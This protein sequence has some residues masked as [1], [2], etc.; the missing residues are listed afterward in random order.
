MPEK[1]NPGLV[2]GPHYQP[3][4]PRRRQPQYRMVAAVE[5]RAS[6][7][8]QP[9]PTIDQGNFRDSVLLNAALLLP[10]RRLHASQREPR[11]HDFPG[12]AT[13]PPSPLDVAFI[14]RPPDKDPAD[15]SF[16]DRH[17]IWH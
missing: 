8:M 12:L 14:L 3:T 9:P 5:Q 10:S 13:Q 16:S 17:A 7:I 1:R 15:D 2:Y 4:V 11:H 6:A